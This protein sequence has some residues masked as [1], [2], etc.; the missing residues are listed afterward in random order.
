LFVTGTR[1]RENSCDQVTL[2][3]HVTVGTH[4]IHHVTS[5]PL[6]YHVIQLAFARHVIYHLTWTQAQYGLAHSLEHSMN[7]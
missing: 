4:M 5:G 3:S 6:G 1:D 2:T 7:L